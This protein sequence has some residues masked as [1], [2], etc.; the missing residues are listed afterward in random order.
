MS[1]I[2]EG[3]LIEALG[4]TK[5]QMAKAAE[6]L[7]KDKNTKNLGNLSAWLAKW[8][9][10]ENYQSA[11]IN[12]KEVMLI[13]Q[14]GTKGKTFKIRVNDFP[15]ASLFSTG[16]Q[17]SCIKYDTASALGLLHQIA[18]SDVYVRTVNRHNMDIKGSVMVSFQIW[19]CIFTHKFIVCEGLNRSFILGEDFLNHHCFMLCWTDKNKRFAEYRGNIIAVA[20]QA[21]MDDRIMVACPVKIPARNFAMVPTECPNM[22]SG[23]VKASPCLKFKNKL[24]NLYMEIMQ[25]NNPNSK[26]QEVTPYIKINLDYDSHIYISKDVM[27]YLSHYI[28]L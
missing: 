7:A 17:V 9:N 6:I 2:T 20:S 14:G 5:N 22:F 21:V 13:Q 28:T 18:D 26:L 3:D 27:K 10:P 8:Y 4:V 25:Y 16:V 1:K 24:P 23:R 12:K 15:F 19:S 11:D